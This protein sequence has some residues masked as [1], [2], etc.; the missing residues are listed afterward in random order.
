MCVYKAV[1]ARRSSDSARYFK[2]SDRTVFKLQSW[3][4][5]MY[6]QPWLYVTGKQCIWSEDILPLVSSILTLEKWAWA[7]VISSSSCVVMIYG[8]FLFL[9]SGGS[10]VLCRNLPLLC[11]WFLGDSCGL[12]LLLLPDTWHLNLHHFIR[13][14]LMVLGSMQIGVGIVPGPLLYTYRTQSGILCYRVWVKVWV[15]VVG[16]GFIWRGGVVDYQNQ[17]SRGPCWHTYIQ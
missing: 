15:K 13:S 11:V 1:S 7:P 16:R 10:S 8:Y 14:S 17:I 5:M 3:R 12:Y 2:G 9:L 6:F 4:T